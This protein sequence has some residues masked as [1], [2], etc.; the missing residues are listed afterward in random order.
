MQSKLKRKIRADKGSTVTSVYVRALARRAR[1]TYARTYA[2]RWA[3]AVTRLAGDDVQS[4]K[5]DDLLVAL[6]RANKIIGD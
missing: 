6:R 1:V 2:D 4:D 5:T 3:E